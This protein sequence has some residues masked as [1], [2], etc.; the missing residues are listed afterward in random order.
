M[1]RQWIWLIV[2]YLSPF[3]WNLAS[4]QTAKAL[5]D[6]TPAWVP[7]RKIYPYHFQTIALGARRADGR[8]ELIIAEPP[9]GVTV[10][11]LKKV[12]PSAMARLFLRRQPVGYDGWIQDAVVDLPPFNDRE[13]G[14]L[15]D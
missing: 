4:A 1:N 12:D 6:E 2:L 13:L 3:H 14:V 8:R 5:E 7:F 11:A 15:L 10:E 9:P